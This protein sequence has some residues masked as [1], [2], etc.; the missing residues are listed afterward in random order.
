M[1][2][3]ILSILCV[4]VASGCG[5]ESKNVQAS[6]TPAVNENAKS[7]E[8]VASKDAAVKSAD[9]PKVVVEE[10][11]AVIEIAKD[12]DVKACMEMYGWMIGTRA[13]GLS[14]LALSD[15]E[16]ASFIDGIKKAAKEEELT[17]DLAVVG[18]QMQDYIQKKADA[19]AKIKEEKVAVEAKVQREKGQAFLDNLAKNAKVKKTDS[20][21]FYEVIT[22]GTGATPTEKDLLT[23]HYEGS[24]IDG[25]VF[26]SSIARGQPATFRLNFVIPGFKEGLSLMKKGGKAKIYIPA[27]LAY[28]DS[29]LP[30]IPA[31]STLIFNVEL[32]DVQAIKP[33]PE[34]APTVEKAPVVESAKEKTP[35]TAPVNEKAKPVEKK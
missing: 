1:K 3:S 24:L 19:Y 12:V 5:A 25:K 16:I 4:C 21:L 23:V 33:Q 7:T 10:K 34:A 27:D 9:A 31:G 6:K 18:P 15:A 2:K 8:S 14:D 22:E 32:V 28:G 20:G 26:D 13:A 17:F 29:K 35:V 30:S 11:V